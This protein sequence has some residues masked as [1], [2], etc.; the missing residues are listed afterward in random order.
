MRRESAREA[1]PPVH[2]AVLRGRVYNELQLNGAVPMT[3]AHSGLSPFLIPVTACR[4]PAVRLPGP[5][6]VSVRRADKDS[7]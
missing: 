7:P 1:G 4:F 2:S 5:R 6:A 3:Q